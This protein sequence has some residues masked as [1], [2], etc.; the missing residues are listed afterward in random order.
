MFFGPDGPVPRF[1]ASAMPRTKSLRRLVLLA[2][3]A[4]LRPALFALPEEPRIEF[5][6]M[7]MCPYAQR[8]WIALEEKGIPYSRRV[9]NLKNK[10]EV[11]W[12]KQNVNPLGKVPAIRDSDG[13]TLYESEIINEYLEQKFDCGPNLMPEDAAGCAHVKLW[14]HHLNNK[15]S[16]AHFTF[17]MNKNETADAELQK[18]LEDALQYYEDNLQGPYLAGN[19][20]LADISALPFFERLVFSCRKFKTYEIPKRMVKLQKWLET[21]MAHESFLVT[22]RPE[23]KLEEVYKMFLSMNYKFGGLNRN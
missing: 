16:P 10:T 19:F 11:D 2:P 3:L 17:L 7:D 9:V 15:L 21:A 23:H 12:Y 20:S 18:A 5:Y 14:N 8:T 6:T 13:T 1:F 22:K 4:L